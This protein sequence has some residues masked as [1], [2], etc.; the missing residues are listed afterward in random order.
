MSSDQEEEE[1][2]KVLEH[3]FTLVDFSLF[4]PR[5]DGGGGQALLQKNMQGEE[6]LSHLNGRRFVS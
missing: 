3:L 6:S 5:N 1:E 4:F 2:R